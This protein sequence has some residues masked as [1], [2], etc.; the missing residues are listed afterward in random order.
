MSGIEC[1]RRLKARIPGVKVIVLTGVRE[2]RLVSESVDAGVDG[3][4]YK[5]CSLADCQR[6]IREA[7]EGGSPFSA[8]ANRVVVEELLRFHQENQAAKT[9]TSQER[10]TLDWV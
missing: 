1:T 3:F 9:L 8:D 2:D 5:P 10:R 4:L 6:A 7:L